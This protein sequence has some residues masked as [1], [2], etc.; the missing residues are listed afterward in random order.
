MQGLFSDYASAKYKKR[1]KSG[2]LLL[3]LSYGTLFYTTK[4]RL[5][6]RV[7]LDK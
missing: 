6:H 4:K 3:K 1:I 5:Q 2:P 7:R